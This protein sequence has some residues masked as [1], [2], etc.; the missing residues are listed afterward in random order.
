MLFDTARGPRSAG[1]GPVTK[2]RLS[3][4]S[5]VGQSMFVFIII[6]LVTIQIINRPVYKFNM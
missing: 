3:S 1:P 6:G 2:G 4:I 5:I